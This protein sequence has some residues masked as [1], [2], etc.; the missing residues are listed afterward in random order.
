MINKT[1]DENWKVQWKTK[2]EENK[3]F[4]KQDKAMTN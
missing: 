2:I 3:N 1:F 4:N